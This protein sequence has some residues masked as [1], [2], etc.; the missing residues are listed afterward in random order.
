M[1]GGVEGHIAL[2]CSMNISIKWQMAGVKDVILQWQWNG[3]H[4]PSD[5][6][7]MSFAGYVDQMFGK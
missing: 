6:F 3:G 5:I 2:L 1:M 4:V 7:S